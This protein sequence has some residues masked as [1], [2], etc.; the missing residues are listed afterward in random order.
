[1]E[2]P[3]KRPGKSLE[4]GEQTG[5]GPGLTMVHTMDQ[6]TTFSSTGSSSM[7]SFDGGIKTPPSIPSLLNVLPTE[8]NVWTIHIANLFVLV[9]Q[10]I[11]MLVA[12]V[13]ERFGARAESL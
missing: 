3:D 8:Q 11:F 12:D 2:S 10:G 1:M 4:P 9:G 13:A 7:A 6:Y 5:R